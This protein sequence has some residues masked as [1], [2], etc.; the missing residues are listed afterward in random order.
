MKMELRIQAGADGVV[1]KVHVRPG[2][3][4]E[5]GQRLVEMS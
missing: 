3:V 2:Q 4:V 5:R 1:S